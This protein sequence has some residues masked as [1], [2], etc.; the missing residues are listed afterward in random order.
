[1]DRR[2]DSTTAPDSFDGGRGCRG[3]GHQSEPPERRVL[4]PAV[5]SLLYDIDCESG[6]PYD[7]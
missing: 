2:T 4:A 3:D 6:D 5:Q 7:L 1:M